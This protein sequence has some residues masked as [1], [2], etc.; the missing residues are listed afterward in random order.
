MVTE[1]EGRILEIRPETHD[2]KTFVLELDSEIP[3]TAGQ[4]CLVSLVDREGLSGE[5]RPFTF[6][7]SPDAEDVEIT[8][9]RAG[10]FTTAMHDLSVNDRLKLKG[11]LGKKLQ[12]DESIQEDVVFLTGGSGITPFMSA[13]RYAVAK[14]L[15]NAITLM[16]SNKTPG[17]IIFRDELDRLGRRENVTVYHTLTADVPAGWNGLTGRID[18]DMIADRIE[19]RREKIWYVCG[20]PPMVEALE[21]TLE[22]M[23]IPESM[24]R[25]ED[26]Q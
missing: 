9:K 25:I 17:D 1:T 15:P 7:S 19:E 13:I 11:P 10:A 20:P 4:H 24:R 6:A 5:T 23:E 12:F 16:Y 18:A 8:V 14:S 26:W 3:F 22:E 2:V 21:R